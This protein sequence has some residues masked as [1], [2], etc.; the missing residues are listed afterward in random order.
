MTGKVDTRMAAREED[1]F[2]SICTEDIN[3]ETLRSVV[4]LAVEIAREGR[5]GR[6][7]GTMFVVSDAEE[8]LTLQM[9]DPRSL[10]ASSR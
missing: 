10:V 1:L 9:P 2:V 5:E 3:L 6:K 4:V 8:V 7:V